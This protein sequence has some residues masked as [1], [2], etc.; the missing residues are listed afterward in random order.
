MVIHSQVV[1]ITHPCFGRYYHI[2]QLFSLLVP[3]PGEEEAIL[4]LGIIALVPGYEVG[5]S[6]LWTALPP[7]ALGE[8]WAA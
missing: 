7:W 8:N 2:A 6:R 3:S 1:N 4:E 5:K